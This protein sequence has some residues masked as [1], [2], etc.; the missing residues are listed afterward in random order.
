M[1]GNGPD[2][3]QYRKMQPEEDEDW[4]ALYGRIRVLAMAKASMMAG[5][6]YEEEEFE[7]GARTLRTL[8]GAADI[9]RKLKDHDADDKEVNEESEVP[10]VTD[11][12]IRRIKE[13]IGKQ[14]DRIERMECAGTEEK[15]D[16]RSDVS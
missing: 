11:E 8:M 10:A 2:T 16:K 12:R 14:V 13:G 1:T 4:Q 6:G 3:G 15:T 5:R 7:R 9:A